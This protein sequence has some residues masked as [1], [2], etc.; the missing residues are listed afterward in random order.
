M[1]GS[2]VQIF[3]EESNVEVSVNESD[4]VV[5]SVENDVEVVVSNTVATIIEGN[6]G[7]QGPQGLP[8]VDGIGQTGPAGPTGPQGPAGPQGEPGPPG[9]GGGGGSG[10][11]KYSTNI[12][13]GVD[14]YYTITH[15]LGTQD[16]HPMLYD[17]STN[18]IVWARI[19]IGDG[20]GAFKTTKV[21][22]SFNEPPTSN[23]YRLVVLG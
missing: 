16:V 23:K 18:D 10:A 11:L 3:I 17:N 12:G 21:T 1:S 20:T 9:S 19:D 15:N 7:P 22:V 6:S 14:Q 4:V 13:N 5:L 2:P 8:G